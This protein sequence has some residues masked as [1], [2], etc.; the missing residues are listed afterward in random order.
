MHMDNKE[1]VHV[2]TSGSQ[3]TDGMNPQIYKYRCT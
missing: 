1:S 2:L 3:K